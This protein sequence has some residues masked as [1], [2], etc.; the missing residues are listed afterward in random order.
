MLNPLYHGVYCFIEMSEVIL[1]VDPLEVNVSGIWGC[2]TIDV[3]CLVFT[4]LMNTCFG[5]VFFV[6]IPVGFLGHFESRA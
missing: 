4:S 5:V 1:I 6:F 3:C 2:F